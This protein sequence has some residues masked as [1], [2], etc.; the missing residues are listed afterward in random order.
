MYI[1]RVI[2]H[3]VA[4]IKHPFFEGRK[5]LIVQKL[6]LNGTPSKTYDIAVD[7]VQA[8]IGD[9]VLIVDEGSGARQILHGGTTAPVRAVVAGIID[10][11]EITA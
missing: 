6:N 2:G 1:G 5:L 7:D 9:K 10:D 4:T 11:V 8:G 3:V